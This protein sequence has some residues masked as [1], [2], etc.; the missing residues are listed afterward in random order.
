MSVN[1]YA[2][3][4]ETEFEI[5]YPGFLALRCSLASEVDKAFGNLYFKGVLAARGQY[6]DEADE[7]F[8]EAEEALRSVVKGPMLK[9]LSE[10]FF[11][12]DSDGSCDYQAAGYLAPLA[13]SIPDPKNSWW[14]WGKTNKDFALWLRHCQLNKH[15]ISWH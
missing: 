13:L 8:D 14:R 2:N 10:F 5:G 6:F 12:S 11:S 15:T 4:A 9:S 7:Y 1:F 3:G